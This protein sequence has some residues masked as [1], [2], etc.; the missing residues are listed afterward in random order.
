M[1]F[2][3]T[4][5]SEDLRETFADITAVLKQIR[6][7]QLELEAQAIVTRLALRALLRAMPEEARASVA[8]RLAEPPGSLLG[9]ELPPDSPLGRAVLEEAARLSAAL[10]PTGG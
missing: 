9:P 4:V 3:P 2:R 8:T 1:A 10:A 7:Q 5:R 6:A